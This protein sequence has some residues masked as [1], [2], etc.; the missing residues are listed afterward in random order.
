MLPM[1]ALEGSGDITLEELKF[2]DE[3]R[4]NSNSVQSEK[5]LASDQFFEDRYEENRWKGMGRW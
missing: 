5:G 4:R 3:A 2:I 1:R